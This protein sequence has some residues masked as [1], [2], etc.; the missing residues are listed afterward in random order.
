MNRSNFLLQAT[1]DRSRSVSRVP[2]KQPSKSNQQKG[3]IFPWMRLA[4]VC[5]VAMVL[6]TAAIA[7]HPC[8]TPP[9]GTMV[10]WYPFDE[11]HG[12][13]SAN[14]ATG[15]NAR[16]DSVPWP[17][18]VPGE[19]NGA[20]DFGGNSYIDSPDSIVTNFGPAGVALC[21]GGNYSTCEGDFSMDVW[22]NIPA[23]INGTVEI[24]DKRDYITGIGYS[25]FLYR[26]PFLSPNTYIGVQLADSLGYTNYE[27]EPQNITTN[28]WQLLAVTVDR[29]AKIH[30]YLDGAA[31]PTPVSPTQF[32]SLR[33]T[34]PL[35]IGANAPGFPIHFFPGSLDELEI[36]NRVLTAAEVNAIYVAGKEGKCR[37]D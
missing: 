37:G 29:L 5:A 2:S 1:E 20:L 3:R 10:A 35:R 14:I 24:V 16:W 27:S 23:P 8:A 4:S 31:V 26:N 25:F 15:N 17:T 6:A 33:N 7:Q 18:P 11:T 22:I 34:A 32:G 28:E 30:W 21:G 36:F 19:V 13:T 12:P 9:V